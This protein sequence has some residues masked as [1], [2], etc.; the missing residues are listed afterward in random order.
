MHTD[1][2]LSKFSNFSRIART[3][4][5]SL[6]VILAGTRASGQVDRAVL[7]GTVTDPSGSVIVG[8]TLKV[9][10]IDTGL[11]EQQPTNSRATTVFRVWPWANI[12]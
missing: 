3:V 10:A 12:R 1:S 2:R 7:E 11:T 6:P 8:A 5:L 9:V 4:L